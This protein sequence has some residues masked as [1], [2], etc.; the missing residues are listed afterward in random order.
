M[1]SK[2][3]I[4][5]I[6][7]AIFVT[8]VAISTFP[9]ATALTQRTNFDDNHYTFIYLGGPKVCGDHLCAPGEWDKWIE[10]M[11]ASQL[12]NHVSSNTTPSSSQGPST[13]KP[14]AGSMNSTSTA[15]T[16][17]ST[18]PSTT[19]PTNQTSA[20][21]MNQTSA[22]NQTGTMPPLANGTK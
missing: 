19:M 3:M 21:P 9:V 13:S 5:V 20:M 17:P 18:A 6:A 14:S 2:L 10:N 1:S 22:M 11:Y 12:K 16:T 8:T 4:A 7:T 15:P